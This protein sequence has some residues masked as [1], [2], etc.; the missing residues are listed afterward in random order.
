MLK[1]QV[2]N[3][4]DKKIFSPASDFRPRFLLVI[5]MFFLSPYFFSNGFKTLVFFIN[6][7]LKQ[8]LCMAY[9]KKNAAFS[10]E[11][12]SLQ[13]V[14]FNTSLPERICSLC[15]GI[16]GSVMYYARRRKFPF[17]NYLYSFKCSKILANKSSLFCFL[18]LVLSIENFKSLSYYEAPMMIKA[19]CN[20]VLN[21]KYS[22]ISRFARQR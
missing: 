21:F 10:S 3:N 1:H 13:H 20:P 2:K 12:I 22:I 19:S 15:Q 16:P 4:I 5:Q 7:I 6:K 9:M 18:Y 8:L 14:H 17:S 11:C